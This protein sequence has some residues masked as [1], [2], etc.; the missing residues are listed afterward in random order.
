MAV[1][2]ATFQRLRINDFSWYEGQEGCVLAQSLW[3]LEHMKDRAM[4]APATADEFNRSNIATYYEPNVRL[5]WTRDE[6]RFASVAWRSAFKQ[7][8]MI[9]QPV[10]RP[11]LMKYNHNGLGVLQI[12]GATR[13]LDLEAYKIGMLDGDGFWTTGRTARE[14]KNVVHGRPN[15]RVAPLVRQYTAM[16]ALPEGPTL[17]VDFCRADDQIWLLRDGSLGLRL[18]A[19]IFTNN[20]VTIAANGAPHAW[21]QADCRDTWHDLGSR[22]VT[23]EG[24]LT[25]HALAGDGT[26]QLMQKRKRPADRSE[27]LYGDEPFGA[28]ESLLTHELYFGPPA[29]DRPRIVS[30]GEVFRRNVL[31]LYC[32]PAH[33]PKEPAGKVIGEF[34]CI[35]VQLPDVG[36]T[37][38]VN[39][40]DT[41]QPAPG[42][43]AG[44][45]V[46]PQSVRVTA[47]P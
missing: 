47:A 38:A 11:N 37:I 33:T 28:D 20:Q 7:W 45:R 9:V 30:P 19:D 10:D 39:F 1:R 13:A 21:G 35:T 46:P 12:S 43:P 44:A 26:F 29:Y 34:P 31:V 41:E 23:V 8:Q 15:N 32:D 3:L 4:P 24:D 14:S 18:A 2:L 6:H 17:F 42:D 36:R 40:A 16:V 25:I 27:M 22:T 5:A